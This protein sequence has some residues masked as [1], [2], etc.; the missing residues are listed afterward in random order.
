MLLLLFLLCIVFPVF[1]QSN[2]LTVSGYL[3]QVYESNKY[4]VAS[5]GLYKS[6]KDQSL[7]GDYL[8]SPKFISSAQAGFT[9]NPQLI[10]NFP[11]FLGNAN[12]LGESYSV[13]VQQETSIGLLWQFS[14]ATNRSQLKTIPSNQLTEVFPIEVIPPLPPY[15]FFGIVNVSPASLFSQQPTWSTIQEITVKQ[16]LW[17]NAFGQGTRAKAKQLKHEALSKSYD[18]LSKIQQMR[19]NTESIYWQ[20]VISR[21][22]TEIRKE[23]FEESERLL[24]FMEKMKSESLSLESEVYQARSIFI[25]SR[26]DYRKTGEKEVSAAL[27][28]NSLRGI[29]S[30]E[31]KE[32][33]FPLSPEIIDLLMPRTKGIKSNL[34]ANKE[35]IESQKAQNL[36]LMQDILPDCYISASFGLQG[37]A[38]IF[39]DS[40]SQSVSKPYYQGAIQLNLSI[41]LSPFKMGTIKRSF[42]NNS[43]SLDLEY[44]RMKF[45]HDQ[46]W[47][48]LHVRLREQREL[49]ALLNE[50]LDIQKAKYENAKLEYGNGLISFF[51][52][53]ASQ[54]DYQD[55]KISILQTYQI[56]IDILLNLSL[57]EPC[58]L[59]L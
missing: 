7:E 38:P 32:D 5:T 18:E 54:S 55:A 51:T 30:P 11:L 47:D 1:P 46:E 19:I 37:S 15:E 34:Q 45:E 16:Y 52:V 27:Q 29:S 4:Y 23:I 3:K 17:K 36:I 49:L 44:Q 9:Q 28:F 35:R 12:L 21:A 40:F 43:R 59:L 56:I 8:F 6:Y 22:L 50:N 39:G 13:G 24:Q 41:P 31:V 26:L 10:P 58:E 25:A 14:S 20:L 42:K 48:R 2:F 33:L 57:Y 53:T